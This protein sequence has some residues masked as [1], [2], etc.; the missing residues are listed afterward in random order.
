MD[1][2][3]AIVG[4]GLVGATLACALGGTGLTVALVEER[5]RQE[6]RFDPARG[7]GARVSAVN[8][9]SRNILQTYGIWDA[10]PPERL[11]IFRQ[12]HVWDAAGKGSIHFDSADIGVPALGYIIE[13]QLLQ[14][15]MET[16]LRQLGS[17]Q[18]L[19]PASL[20]RVQV[21]SG[22]ARLLLS[23]GDQLTVQ[24]VVGADGSRSRVRELTGIPAVVRDYAQ[25]ALVAT[26]KTE[27]R[28]QETAWQRFLPDGPLAFLP[29]PEG[30][31]SIVWTTRP[32]PAGV[33]MEMAAAE[34]CKELET[35]FASRLG[36]ITEMEDR[37]IFP[38]RSLQVRQYVRPRLALVGDAAHTIHPLAGQ[39]VNLGF[40]DAASLTEAIL[41]SPRPDGD[42]GNLAA[43]R[44][45]ERWRKGHNQAMGAI[46][47]GFRWLFGESSFPWPWLRNT[48]LRA[49]DRL[50][51]FKHAIIR[52]AAGLAGDLPAAARPGPVKR[53]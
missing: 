25:T 27:V 30:Y 16:R 12:M 11:G 21:E 20:Q 6:F 48:G 24:L 17:V 43:L 36:A 45:Y 15:A 50:G 29:L 8:L 35:A 7:Y 32:G 23:T 22:Q 42:A 19:R 18:W 3:I 39:G 47:D 2:Q 38:L 31:S 33:L 34:F 5:P 49:S 26:V 44:Y 51:P 4:G 14:E 10:L 53:G 52:H 1:F 46:M 9:A 28:H 40:L 13:N 41:R 37:S